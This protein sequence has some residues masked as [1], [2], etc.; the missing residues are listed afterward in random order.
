MC[1]MKAQAGLCSLIPLKSFFSHDRKVSEHSASQ[2]V[3]RVPMLTSVQL[4]KTSSVR[5]EPQSN[6]K[7]WLAADGS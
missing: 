3:G 7:R 2:L 6:R 4:Q 5:A 1:Y